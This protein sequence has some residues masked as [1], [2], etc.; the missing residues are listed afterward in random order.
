MPQSVTQPL[1]SIFFPPFFSHPFP[2][3]LPISELSVW[4]A[5]D[6]FVGLT[7]QMLSIH[8]SQLI[9]NVLYNALSKKV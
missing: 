3:I 7:L 1:V 2:I 6:P 5:D 8:P 9:L 4:A